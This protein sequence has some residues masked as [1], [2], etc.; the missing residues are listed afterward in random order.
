LWRGDPAAAARQRT[1]ITRPS[2][3]ATSFVVVVLLPIAVASAYYLAIAAGQYVAEFRF[4]LN[5]GDAPRFDAL[6]ML[7]GGGAQSSSALESQIAVQYITSRAIVDQIDASLD[8]RRLF[9]PPQADWWARLPRAVPIEEL[10]QYWRGQVD[11][12]Y[13]PATG[14][15]TVRVRT[16]APG[17]ALRLAQAVVT[18]TEKLVNELATRSRA[19]ALRHSETEVTQ[20]ETR[21]NAVLADIRA[22]RDREG[23]IDPARTADATSMLASRLRED[24][25]GANAQLATLRA[26]MREDA[27]P[28]KVLKARIRS[29]EAQQRSLAQEMTG[30]DKSRPQTLSAV[31]AS[32]EELESQHK[33]AETAYQHALQNLDQA[34]ANA[35]R[36]H[37][38]IANFIP[39]SLPEEALYPR[40]WRSLG[41]VA[42]MAFAVWC[43]G[44]L[45]VQSIRDHVA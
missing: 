17:D 9:A 1:A 25:I 45:A 38:F 10:V 33:F 11:P 32:Y 24:V 2:L 18:A 42:L 23:M 29:L 19:D 20:A 5:N 7:A 28:V 36:Q 16:F 21:L 3:R 37:V 30:A 14:T 35:D 6:S 27:P 41:T 13:D 26:Y 34:R 43:I 44:G 15:V 8:L 12:F 40:R 31:L 22:F 39:P 4:T